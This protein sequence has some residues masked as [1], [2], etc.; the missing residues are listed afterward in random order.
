MII[1][2]GIARSGLT[3]T[4]QM[5]HAGEYPA[6]EPYNIGEIPWN[7]CKGLAVKL[8]D[9]QLHIP[10]RGKKQKIIILSRNLTQ[11]A[12]SLNKFF[13][14]ITGLPLTS[15]TALIRSLKRDYAVIYRWARKQRTLALKFEDII[16][17]PLEAAKAIAEFSGKNLNIEKMAGVVI[18]RTPECHPELLELRMIKG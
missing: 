9:A 12:R 15:E 5:L 10:P 17:K 4:M 6:F 16:N 7:A 14:A 2:A 18:D 11:Q 13:G 8:V 3:V 1:V